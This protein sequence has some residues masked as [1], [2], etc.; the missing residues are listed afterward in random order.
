MM[1]CTKI[2]WVFVVKAGRVN[3]EEVRLKVGGN[4]ISEF[5]SFRPARRKRGCKVS[6]LPAEGGVSMFHGFM[7]SKFQNFKISGLPAGGGV[8]MLQDCPP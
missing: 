3:L 2:P 5:Q 7:V 1:L 8:T 6:G 4:F